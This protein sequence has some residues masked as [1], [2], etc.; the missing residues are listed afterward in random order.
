MKFIYGIQIVTNGDLQ[1]IFLAT[2]SF[3]FWINPSS[4]EK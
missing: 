3:L 4:L 1:I 2:S